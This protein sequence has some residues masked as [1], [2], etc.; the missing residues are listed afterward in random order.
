MLETKSIV[1]KFPKV[2]TENLLAQIPEEMER[3]H[4]NVG[5]FESALEQAPKIFE[6]VGVNLPVNIPLG[7][8]NNLVSES[9]F[10]KSLIR[11]GTHR[12]RSRCQPRCA[13]EFGSGVHVSGDCQRQ[14]RECARYAPTSP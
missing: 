4:A 14:Q 1:S 5:A 13:S 7:M 2:V 9:L 10:S 6:S 11:T 8:V 3:F 12:Y